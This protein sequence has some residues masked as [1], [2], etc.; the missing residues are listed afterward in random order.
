M[1]C[2]QPIWR[3]RQRRPVKAGSVKELLDEIRGMGWAVAVH[4]DY[5]LNGEDHTFW[6]FTKDDRAA[7]GEGRTDEDA[8]QIVLNK[9]RPKF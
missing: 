2:L 3:L 6:L 1:P 9:V 5:R 7:K 8:L 4:N